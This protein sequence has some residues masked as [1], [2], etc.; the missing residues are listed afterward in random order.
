VIS[1]PL[2]VAA[3]V[4]AGFGIIA[5]S[6]WFKARGLAGN[7]VRGVLGAIALVYGALTVGLAP[8]GHHARLATVLAL[9]ALAF[10]FWMHDTTSNLVGA[11]RDIDGDRAGGYETLPVRRGARFAVHT[12]ISLYAVAFAAAVAGGLLLPKGWLGGYLIWL[13]AVLAMGVMALAPLLA[14]RDQMPVLVALRAHAVLVV[15]RVVLAA[16]VVGLGLGDGWALLLA[17]P[18]AALSWWTQSAMRANH[19]LGA[20]EWRAPDSEPAAAIGPRISAKDMS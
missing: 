20:R 13:A 1:G 12:V 2:A 15:E 4:L 11:L 14:H 16:A 17:A 18:L 7:L 5:Y 9:A 10:A 8:A 19:E 6:R 3:A